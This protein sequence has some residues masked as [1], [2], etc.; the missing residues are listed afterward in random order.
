MQESLATLT[1]HVKASGYRGVPFFITFTAFHYYN[2]FA[3]KTESC[4][5]FTDPFKP[6][7]LQYAEAMT[8]IMT[9]RDAQMAIL[10][11]APQF[12]IVDVARS[13][14]SRRTRTSRWRQAQTPRL[15]PTSA[16]RE[17]QTRGWTSLILT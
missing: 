15:L 4:V 9:S 2:S 3:A 13:T 17:S 11:R 8:D 6:K 12:K 1:R 7:Q 14:L 16:C 10:R 5:G